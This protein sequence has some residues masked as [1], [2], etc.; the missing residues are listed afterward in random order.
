ME[1]VLLK[2]MSEETLSL[3]K[4]V[5]MITD[6]WY[7]TNKQE[8]DGAF[9]I[10]YEETKEMLL[11]K[12]NG[13]IILIPVSTNEWLLLSE[14]K[15][16]NFGDL[17]KMILKE[18]EKMIQKENILGERAYHL[19]REDLLKKETMLLKLLTPVTDR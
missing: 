1:E 2:L 16:D 14:D 17:E 15:K 10:L 11:Q 3:L 7:L 19:K 13:N 18:N 6:V 4:E 8:Y 12:F 5:G 9:T